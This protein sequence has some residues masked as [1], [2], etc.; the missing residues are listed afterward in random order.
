MKN[1]TPLHYAIEKKLKD[2]SIIL[3]SNGANCNVKDIIYSNF[4]L[5]HG[6]E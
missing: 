1:K 5:I 3:I 4:I 6:N 2:I